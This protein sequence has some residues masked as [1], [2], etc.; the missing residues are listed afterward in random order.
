MFIG[1]FRSWFCLIVLLIAFNSPYAQTINVSGTWKGYLSQDDKTWAFDMIL[2]LQQ[3]QNVVSGTSKII[4]NDGSGAYVVH[5]VEGYL[6]AKT[7]HLVDVSVDNENNSG[8][9]SWCKKIYS[10]RIDANKDSAAITGIW[11]N[12]GT[13]IFR[14]KGLIDNNISYCSPGTIKLFKSPVPVSAQQPAT[15]VVLQHKKTADTSFLNRK[16]ELKNTINVSSDSVK[17]LFFDNGEVDNDIISIYYNKVLIL[18][19]KQLSNKALEVTVKIEANKDNEILM[20]AE[21]EGTTPP[22]TALMV[23]YDRGMRREI[24]IDSSTKKSEVVVLKKNN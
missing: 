21:N 7:M 8:Y 14:N 2:N 4:A 20:F 15:E 6:D 13:K 1:A 12:D 5:R 19:N 9:I 24:T 22:N 11:S 10:C 16:V 18:S 3:A 17:L 23:F